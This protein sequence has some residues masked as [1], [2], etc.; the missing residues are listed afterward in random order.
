MLACMSR[1]KD[2]NHNDKWYLIKEKQ[3]ISKQSGAKM[4]QI[5][6]PNAHWGKRKKQLEGY[7]KRN[8]PFRTDKCETSQPWAEINQKSMNKIHRSPNS[9]LNTGTTPPPTSLQGFPLIFHGVM[10]KDEREA[11]SPSFFNVSEIEVLVDYLI[12]LLETQGKEGLPKLSAK[13]IGIIAPYRKQVSLHCGRW[14][15]RE[16]D[17]QF[18]PV[19]GNMLTFL[20]RSRKSKRPWSPSQLLVD[21]VISQSSRLVTRNK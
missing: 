19:I 10:G 15:F 12:K 16:V 14:C 18:E 1:K 8:A 6:N 3:C 21:G 7:L 2:K 5:K 17:K 9:M 11:N 4:K 13:D 20:T